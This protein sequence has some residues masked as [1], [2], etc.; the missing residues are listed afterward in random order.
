MNIEGRGLT[1]IQLGTILYYLI[2][3]LAQSGISS[4]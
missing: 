2:S 3:F 1:I 4:V